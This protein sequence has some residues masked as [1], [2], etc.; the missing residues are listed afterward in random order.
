LVES[1]LMLQSSGIQ[2]DPANTCPLWL[3]RYP[4]SA[5]ANAGI[6]KPPPVDTLK[7]HFASNCCSLLLMKGCLNS[8]PLPSA[9]STASTMLFS[10]DVTSSCS[11]CYT[12]DCAGD[13]P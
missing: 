6:R 13:V 4:S 8:M 11:E 9:F 7:A 5:R 12:F 3:N 2:S 10:A 1:E